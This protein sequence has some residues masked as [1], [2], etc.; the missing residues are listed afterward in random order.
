MIK[1]LLGSTTA[2]LLLL[3]ADWHSFWSLHRICRSTWKVCGGWFL[4]YNLK[5]Q[6]WFIICLFVC[7]FLTQITW[8]STC[9]VWISVILLAADESG[10]E[11][12]TSWTEQ[13]CYE[14][15]YPFTLLIQHSASKLQFWHHAFFLQELE[16]GQGC[17][18]SGTRQEQ[19][20]NKTLDHGSHIH[21]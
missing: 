17:S 4:K 2:V 18:M 19:T 5:W 15:L 13:L 1:I 21:T 16:P 14:R 11:V 3:E 6:K 7:F 10:K 12:A 9:S 8:V 20:L